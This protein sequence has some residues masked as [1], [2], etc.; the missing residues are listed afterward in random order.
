MGERRC[1]L[2]E[3]RIVNGRCQECGMNYSSRRT[4]RLNDGKYSVAGQK[5]RTAAQQRRPS[6]KKVNTGQKTKEGN[7]NWASYNKGMAMKGNP[8]EKKNFGA[9]VAVVVVVIGV[10]STAGEWLYDGVFKTQSAEEVLW[11]DESDMAYVPG[12]YAYDPYEYV[13]EELPEGGE[14]MT[15]VLQPGTYVGGC[16]LPVGQYAI[17]AVSGLGSVVLED[18]DFISYRWESLAA[19]ELQTED[20][21]SYGETSVEDFRLFEG[22][23]LKVQ[24]GMTVEVSS[25]NA[26]MDDRREAQEN[27]QNDTIILENG[28]EA[29]KDFPAGVYDLTVVRDY[30][31][32]VIKRGDSD[33]FNS[34]LEKG[35]VSG[36]YSNLELRDGDEIIV[37]EEYSGAEF[38]V[39]LDAC[40]EIYPEQYK[41]EGDYNG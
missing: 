2:C 39:R 32:V 5:D 38:E 8:P 23:T 13:T 24:P 29:G 20:D 22:W 40:R 9:V 26:Q 14:S 31:A 11:E 1:L 19:E 37:E 41:E 35:A 21:V 36:S 25:D 34:F 12:N 33:V 28:M 10:L 4:Y 18:P 16:Q 6:V 30:G 7:R 17:T 3:G 15:A 27:P